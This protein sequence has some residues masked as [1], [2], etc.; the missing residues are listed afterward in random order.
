[1]PLT[2]EEEKKRNRKAGDKDAV[3]FFQ[4]K[5]GVE[6]SAFGTKTTNYAPGVSVKKR[7]TA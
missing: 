5:G 1:M 2:P 3:G 4:E 7:W 6:N